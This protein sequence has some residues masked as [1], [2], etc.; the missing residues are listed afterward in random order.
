MRSVAVV[1]PASMCAMIPMFRQRFN[2]TV[3][4][5]V[6]L[7]LRTSVRCC[8]SIPVIPTSPATSYRLA[9]AQLPAIGRESLVGFGHAVH[10]FLLLH[11]RAAPIGRIQQL[12]G[13]LVDHA[14]FAAGAPVGD[15][16]AN[17]QRGA[18][19]GV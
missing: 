13:Q 14:L 11:R 2:G 9:K 8:T 1:F 17:G 5:T 4:A 15:Q 16:P 3:R 7:S 18:P 12:I 10:V 6:S 19:L